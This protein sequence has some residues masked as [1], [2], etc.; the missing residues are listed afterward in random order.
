[1][2]QGLCVFFTRGETKVFTWASLAAL[3]VKGERT[4][5]VGRKRES[6][7]GGMFL[8]VGSERAFVSKERGEFEQRDGSL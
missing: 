5:V 8:G 2:L 7:C 4:F 1:M 3:W 6:V